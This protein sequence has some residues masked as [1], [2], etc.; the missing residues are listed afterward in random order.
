[1]PPLSLHILTSPHPFC[2][3]KCVCVKRL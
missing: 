1:L 2:L 3:K